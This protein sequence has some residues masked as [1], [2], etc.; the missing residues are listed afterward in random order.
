MDTEKPAGQDLVWSSAAIVRVRDET[1]DAGKQLEELDDGGGI[2]E[3]EKVLEM[4][5][6]L[7]FV[8][9]SKLFL[10]VVFESLPLDVVRTRKVSED[11]VEF[12]V[13]EKAI[14]YDMGKRLC[15]R[16]AGPEHFW[17]GIELHFEIP[18]VVLGS[19]SWDSFGRDLPMRVSC[20]SLATAREPRQGPGST[21][22]DLRAYSTCA[23]RSAATDRGGE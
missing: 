18:S 21:I 4:R 1:I 19:V 7:G 9:V 2:H 13:R 15:V 20:L 16:V 22:Q 3:I 8:G 14:K 12:I 23:A 6:Q 17:I 11:K 5:R 10:L